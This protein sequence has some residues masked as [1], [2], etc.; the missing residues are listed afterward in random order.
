MIYTKYVLFWIQRSDNISTYV[1]SYP[2]TK[3]DSF[4]SDDCL[5][6]FNNIFKQIG[7][8]SVAPLISLIMTNINLSITST[9]D[10]RK[11]MILKLKCFFFHN[12]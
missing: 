4:Y 12:F 1:Q 2:E 6:V 10:W 8:F 7:T 11:L 3:F 5:Y 9:I